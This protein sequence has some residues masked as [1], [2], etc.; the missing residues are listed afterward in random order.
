[1]AVHWI[2]ADAALSVISDHTGD[3]YAARIALCS[4]A[5][6]GLLSAKA[7][8]VTIGSE[9]HENTF[10]PRGFWW[11]RGHEALEQDWT[12][13]DFST[14][15]DAT[16]EWRVSG[17]T[18]DL[19]GICEMLPAATRPIVARRLSVAG[20]PDWIPALAARAFMYTEMGAPPAAA[21]GLLIEQCRLGFVAAR[22]VKMQRADGGPPDDWTDEAREWDVPQWYW[23]NFT[24]S[25]SSSQQWERGVFS[26]RGSGPHGY[27]W[28]TLSGVYFS[29]DS[30]LAMLPGKPAAK[31]D[32]VAEV[33]QGRPPAAFWDELWCAVFGMIWHGELTPKVQADITRAMLDWASENDHPLSEASAK[34]RARRLFIEYQREAKNP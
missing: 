14:W 17:V 15:I 11:A 28:I 27:S 21:G 26:G 7:R 33:R 2:S 9:R 30:L 19:S 20:D 18:F 13:G 5:S 29:R 12:I 1:M 6:D 24:A 25:E 22:A 16:V 4:R 23:D 31:G 3:E 10:V 8:L 34:P 32:A